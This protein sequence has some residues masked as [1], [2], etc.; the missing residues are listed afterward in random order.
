M[1]SS[2]WQSFIAALQSYMIRSGASIDDLFARITD[3]KACT[4]DEFKTFV[5]KIPEM[6]GKEGIS[7]LYSRG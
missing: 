1:D 3:A 5:E 2:W 6:T 4:L 7:N